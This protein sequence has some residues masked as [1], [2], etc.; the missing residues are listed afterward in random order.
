MASNKYSSNSSRQ[1]TPSNFDAEHLIL[2]DD[3]SVEDLYTK[4]NSSN[5]LQQLP[6]SP[7]H[8]YPIEVET[9]ALPHDHAIAGLGNRGRGAPD[10]SSSTPVRE[11]IVVTRILREL[12]AIAASSPLSM[13]DKRLHLLWCVSRFFSLS[14]SL[15]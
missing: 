9:L 3:N 6:N 1:L 10:S 12:N 4:L 8:T 14:A 2:S 15:A 5:Q 11:N 13:I 7:G